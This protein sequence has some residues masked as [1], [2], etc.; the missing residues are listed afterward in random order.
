MKQALGN[1]AFSAGNYADAVKH[2]TDAIGV[3]AANHV[4]YSNRSAAYAAL[5]DYDAA[6]TDAEKTVAIKPD[7]VKGYS[8]KGA[9]LYGLKRYDDACDAYNKGLEIDGTNDACKSGLADAETA[10]VRAMGAAG[11][12]GDPMG[13]IGA[14][15]SS[16]ELYGKLAT[17]PA[18]RGFLSQPD[19]IAMLTDVQKNPDKF[20]SYMSD[21]R[22]MQVLSVALG[23]NVMS[24]EDAMN[25]PDGM[26]KGAS[27]GASEPEV[28]KPSNPAKPTPAPEPMVV[29]EPSGPKAEAKQEKSA[30]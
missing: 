19:F 2:F 17:N 26:F 18:T 29:D 3:D 14:M 7:W 23:V 20:G 5:N 27:N 13:S 8:R 25:N 28:S 22:M 1:T 4:F 24:G 10:A 16:P 9:A 30:G 6:L 15:L 12:G 21:P 11:P